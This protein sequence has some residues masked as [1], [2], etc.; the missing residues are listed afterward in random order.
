MDLRFK[1]NIIIYKMKS[2]E[3][4]KVPENMDALLMGVRTRQQAKL[5]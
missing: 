2:V 5:K 3:K 1:I 4:S